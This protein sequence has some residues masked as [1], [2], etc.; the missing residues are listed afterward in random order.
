MP[1]TAVSSGPANSTTNARISDCSVQHGLA[2]RDPGALL[3]DADPAATLDHDEPRGIGV[4]VR[5]DRR[6]A[7]ERDLADR[8]ASVGMDELTAH[9]GRAGRTVGPPMADTEP[10]DLDRHRT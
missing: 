1:A 4:G 9:T 10:S 5:L 2:G 6:A 8:T 7:G 3:V